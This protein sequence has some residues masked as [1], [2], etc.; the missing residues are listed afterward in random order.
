MLGRTADQLYWMARY[1]ERAE[2]TARLLDVNSRMA[3]MPHDPKVGASVW[4]SALQV[5]GIDGPAGDDAPPP[6]SDD[7]ISLL[8]LDRTNASSILSCLHA[9]RENARALRASITTELWEALNTTWL[10]SRDLDLAAVRARGMRNF[11]DWVRD[12]SH[13]FRG[14]ISGTMLRDD[15]RGFIDL[16]TYLERAD[17]TAR[18]LDSKYHVLLPEADEVGG[19]VDYYQWGS[20]LRSVSAFRAYNKVYNGAIIP[21]RVAELLVMRQDMP[22]SLHACLDRTTDV[23]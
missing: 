15:S 19:A 9:A 18:L 14:V 10:D 7:V 17:N 21:F 1:M 4:L 5:A 12:R 13:L 6:S 3:L 22:R 23:L 16:G 2:N 8:A 11:F 20:V